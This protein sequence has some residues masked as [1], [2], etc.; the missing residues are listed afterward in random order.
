MRD[1]I[2]SLWCRIWERPG[3]ALERYALSPGAERYRALGVLT[4]NRLRSREAQLATT[5]ARAGESPGSPGARE[6][7]DEP[8]V[9]VRLLAAATALEQR[10]TSPAGRLHP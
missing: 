3:Q 2:F 9:V 6:G 4:F 10:W 7:R 5:A 8:N 1:E